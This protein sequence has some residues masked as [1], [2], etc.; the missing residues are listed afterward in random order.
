MSNPENWEVVISAMEA[1]A[2]SPGGTAYKIGRDAPYRIAAK[3]GTAQVAG[4]SQD[5]KPPD[6]NSLPM[7]LRDHA[8][9][10]AFA[11]ADNPT[12]A[13]GVIAE[14]GGHGG[15]VAGPVARMIMD[16]YLLGE[17]RYGITANKPQATSA[18]SAVAD[19]AAQAIIED[20]DDA[21]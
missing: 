16:Q 15:S 5:D 21:R 12:I 2:Q 1:V 13:V 20:N 7:R 3:T 18:A 8:L 17:V 10:I 19:P 4:L 6:Q 9:F 11:P 14:H